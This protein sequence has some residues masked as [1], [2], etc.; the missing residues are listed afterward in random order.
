[1]LQYSTMDPVVAPKT[2]PAAWAGL[3][4]QSK[5]YIV[6]LYHA[7]ST[8]LGILST[9]MELLAAVV[10]FLTCSMKP[11]EFMT[12]WMLLLEIELYNGLVDRTVIED[13]GYFRQSTSKRIF[14]HFEL[15]SGTATSSIEGYRMSSHVSTHMLLYFGGAKLLISFAVLISCLVPFVIGIYYVITSSHNDP[16][17]QTILMNLV[18]G[19]GFIYFG[20]ASSSVLAEW[21]LGITRAVCSEPFAS[22]EYLHAILPHDED[23]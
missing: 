16:L 3:P 18:A 4:F 21:T 8:I 9:A 10:A 22:Y 2:N 15:G 11:F 7:L 1:M 19:V 23:I 13:H 14:V 12:R 17:L 6:V 20:C 5:T